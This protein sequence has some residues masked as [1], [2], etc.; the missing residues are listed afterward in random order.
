V[1][2]RGKF[3]LLDLS[4]ELLLTVHRRMTGNFL[5]LAP[6]WQIDNG[7]R[8]RNPDMWNIKGPRFFTGSAEATNAAA[9]HVRYCRVCFNLADGR[10]LLFTDPRKFG[11]IELW[12]RQRAHQ[13]H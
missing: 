4:G 10:R 9:Q 5:L 11:R 13:W 3:L 8:V 7:L 2:R 12:Y 6:G 1:R